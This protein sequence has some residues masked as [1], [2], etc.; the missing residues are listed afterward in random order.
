MDGEQGDGSAR[1]KGKGK[2]KEAPP[3][4]PG[5]GTSANR[6]GT[7]PFL[8]RIAHS[9]SSLTDA[10]L[11]GPPSTQTLSQTLSD[12]KGQA[13]STIS[14]WDGKEGAAAGAARLRT[15]PSAQHALSFRSNQTRDH[16]AAEEAAFARFLDDDESSILQSADV[17]T[18]YDP[19]GSRFPR[20][21]E[22]S[23]GDSSDEPYAFRTVAEQE[24]HD[25]AAVVEILSGG[26]SI[27]PDDEAV[28]GQL[29][30]RERENLRRAL[31]GEDA[32]SRPS[33]DIWDDVLNFIPHYLRNGN[34][35]RSGTTSAVAGDTVRS[36]EHLGLHDPDEAWQA[37]V[38]QWSEV[39]SSY[40]DEVWGDLSSLVEQA[41]QEVEQLERV[42]PD[43]TPPQTK[44]L[45]RLRAI[46]GHLRGA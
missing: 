21:G 40:T 44:A 22:E 43:E 34:E 19:M 33:L 7:V 16:V 38:G 28:E 30:P 29:A 4:P 31:F 13:S 10:L 46:L 24:E 1:G 42:R 12:G 8:D 23:L 3:P 14:G 36:V 37:W 41:R 27:L 5:E 2:E 25:G 45:L 17:S 11:G 39:L 6:Q 15:A 18:A 9:A 20:T 26:G 35:G 32:R